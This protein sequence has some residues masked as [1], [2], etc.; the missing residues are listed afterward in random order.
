MS[1]RFKISTLL[2]GTTTND[3]VSVFSEVTSPGSGPPLHSH[4]AQI[5][6][7]HVIE[8]RHR[9]VLDGKEMVALPGDCVLVPVGAAHSF[10]NIDSQ[11]GLLHFELLPS[12]SSEEFFARLV[13]DPASIADMPAFFREH[14][15]QL[16]GPPL[17]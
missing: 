4:V 14:G 9:F 6:I 1:K 12:G 13:A 15:L 11:E 8:G 10:K 3:R 17:D 2:S 5:E 16:L 7:F